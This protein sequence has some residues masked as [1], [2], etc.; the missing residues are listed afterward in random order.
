MWGA[1]KLQ[2]LHSIGQHLNSWLHITT[3]RRMRNTVL[4]G[5]LL[6]QINVGV[7][8]QRNKGEGLFGNKQL[9]LLPWFLLIVFWLLS[10]LLHKIVHFPFRFPKPVTSFQSVG[11]FS[12]EMLSNSI[13]INFLKFPIR[14]YKCPS[15]CCILVIVRGKILKQWMGSLSNISYMCFF[16]FNLL[17]TSSIKYQQRFKYYILI[18]SDYII[19]SCILD[20]VYTF[21]F[22]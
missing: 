18:F 20:L 6:I 9:S 5:K 17:M 4:L 10:L 19:E 7:L 12:P 13:A 8:Y 1:Q 14:V 3:S 15:L 11:H 21:F 22:P 2:A 16:F